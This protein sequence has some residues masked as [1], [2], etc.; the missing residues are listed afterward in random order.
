VTSINSLGSPCSTKYTVVSCIVKFDRFAPN[1]S[2]FLIIVNP[3][4]VDHI[5]SK[6]SWTVRMIYFITGEH[7]SVVEPIH[8]V[9]NDGKGKGLSVKEHSPKPSILLLSRVSKW[10]LKLIC[11][12]YLVLIASL[13]TTLPKQKSKSQKWEN[14]GERRNVSENVLD[15]NQPVKKENNGQN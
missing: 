8:Y 9:C 5:W 1:F 7:S 6:T 12:F 14:N 2:N 10:Y 3:E 4:V 11:L 13:F 15:I